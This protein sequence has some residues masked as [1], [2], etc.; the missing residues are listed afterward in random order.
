MALLTCIWLLAVLL[1]LASGLAVAVHGETSVARNFAQLS[2]ARWAARAGVHRAEA[3]LLALAAEQYTDPGMSHAEW[4][5]AQADNTLGDL[6]YDTV[7]EDEAGKINLNTASPELL[8]AFFPA[9]VVPCL[10]DWR[11]AASAGVVNGAEDDYYLGLSPPYHCK[12]APFSTVGELA[13]VKG[14]TSDLLAASV[15][16]DGRTLEDLLTVSSQDTNTD[17]S[18]QARINLTRATQASLQSAFSGVLTQ[19][20]VAAILAQRRRAAFTSPAD[21][22]LVPSLALTKIAQIY[23]RL[24]TSTSTTRPGLINLNTAPAELLA[25]LPGMDAASAEALVT[26]RE[27]QGAFTQVGEM[28]IVQGITPDA[29][30][31]A[32][33][34]LTTRSSL[35]GVSATG[36][37]Q[38]G[39]H[40]TITCLLQLENQQTTPDL[41]VL[42]WRER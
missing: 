31:Q 18:G 6:S 42:Y 22:V 16:T 23:D 8:G 33:D 38:D 12:N 10:V 40:T 29:F 35:F 34:L 27:K 1:V 26:R 2:R 13:L 21:L 5:S 14:V 25:A 11:S 3:Q 37:D 32:A 15:T 36:Q 17:V 30:R 41:R 28:L 20:D 9:E 24:T 7:V 4:L 19:D 39:L